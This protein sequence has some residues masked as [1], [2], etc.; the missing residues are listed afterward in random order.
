[1]GNIL[2]IYVLLI[3]G[4]CH[5]PG[6]YPSADSASCSGGYPV[7]DPIYNTKQHHSQKQQINASR[8]ILFQPVVFGFISADQ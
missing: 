2:K 1:V 3:Y 6:C 4:Y 5:S 8:E 7:S